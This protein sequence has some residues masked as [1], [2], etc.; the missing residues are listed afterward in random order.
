MAQSTKTNLPGSTVILWAII[1]SVIVL[2]NWPLDI[3]GWRLYGRFYVETFVSNIS[4]LKNDYCIALT[5][6]QLGII[7]YFFQYT[8]PIYD[9]PLLFL[10][11]GVFLKVVEIIL[12]YKFCGA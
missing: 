5:Y 6:D 3:Y 12:V 4:S 10:F 9:F 7:R 1:A 11:A 8:K 2:F